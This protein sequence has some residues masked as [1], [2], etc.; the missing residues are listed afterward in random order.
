MDPTAPKTLTQRTLS[1]IDGALKPPAYDRAGL[2]PSIVHLGV[3]GFHRAHLAT[4]VDELCR[5]GNT[6][7][8]I[9]GSGVMAGD[10]AMRDALDP[11]DTLFT[12]IERGPTASSATVVG[13]MVRYIHAHP[14]PTELVAAIAAPTT[15]IVSLTVTEGG[16]PIDDATGAFDAESPNAGPA[17]A[18]AI[19]AAG[20]ASRMQAGGAPLTIMSCDN[21][22]SNGE[23]TSRATLG[24]AASIGPELVTWVEENVTFPNSMVDRITP[25]TTD[26]DRSWLSDNYGLIDNWPVACEPF[27]QWV[28]E[29]NF[30]GARPPLE[31]LD[32]IITDDVRPYEHMK[33]QLLNAGH[34][35]LAYAAALLGIEF[36][37]DAMADPDVR[38]FV[39]S[40]LDHEAKTSLAAV[41]GL[42]VDAYIEMLIERFSN[43]QIRDQVARLCQDGSGKLP[44]FLLPTVRTHLA[45]GGPVDLGAL[46][47]ASWCQYLLGSTDAG[48]MIDLAMDPLLD[49]A[50]EAAEAS[51]QDPTAFLSFAPVFDE[52]LQS[53]PRLADAFVTALEL[54]RS[55]GIRS[56]VGNATGGLGGTAVS[57]QDR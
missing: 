50:C 18:F 39:R 53:D 42:D 17:S 31:T 8:A 22:M 7:W 34:S 33:L 51:L 55:G 21:I 28:I 11:Q 3:G 9:V 43:P 1:N 57:G 44:K 35:C 25:A 41:P 29:D 36:V 12:V 56:A 37:H 10:A 27:R 16:Y 47:L 14:D 6:D 2:T 13:S 26:A 5:G 49:D 19:I 40:F 45:N 54:I 24:L 4:Y 48:E 15:Q 32:I 23:V 20:L 30:A 52:Q 46:L 38:L